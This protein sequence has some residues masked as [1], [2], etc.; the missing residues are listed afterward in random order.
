MSKTDGPPKLA[1]CDFYAPAMRTQPADRTLEVTFTDANP[2]LIRLVLSTPIVWL[3]R[4]RMKR[5][6]ARRIAG[7]TRTGQRRR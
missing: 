1:G 3:W 6:A 4:P 7:Y 2:D 5:R